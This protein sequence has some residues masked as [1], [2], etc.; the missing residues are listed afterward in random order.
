MRVGSRT[1]AA[2]LA[3]LAAAYHDAIPNIMSGATGETAV[4]EQHPQPS[5]S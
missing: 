3:R 1:F 2:P 4:L 5:A